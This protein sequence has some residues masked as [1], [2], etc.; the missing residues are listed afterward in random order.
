MNKLLSGTL[1]FVCFFLFASCVTTVKVVNP[2][3]ALTLDNGYI[4]IIFTNKVE[5]IA[6]GSRD[7]YVVLRQADSRRRY[8]LPF[9]FSGELRLIAVPPGNY[10]IEEFVYLT[11][12]GSVKGKDMQTKPPGVINWTP[13]PSG[14]NLDKAGYPNDFI[15]DFVVNAGEIVYLGD[16]S[17]E[18][19]LAFGGAAVTINRSFQSDG[20]VFF[21]IHRDYPNMPDSIVFRSLAE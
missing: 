20:P 9:G 3:G 5:P 17:W 21:A 18:G 14:T 2:G 7:V 4:A 6:F 16:Y 19:K 15:K 8:Y 11:G 1:A 13:Q 12:L 10:K